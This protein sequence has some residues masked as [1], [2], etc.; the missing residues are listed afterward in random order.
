MNEWHAS[1]SQVQGYQRLMGIPLSK[2]I[3]L[4]I[5]PTILGEA[6]PTGWIHLSQQCEKMTSLYADT[7]YNWTITDKH[8]RI[9]SKGRTVCQ[10]TVALSRNEQVAATIVMTLMK[11]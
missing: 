5:L 3:P 10:L 6:F 7:F 11:G 2:E 8:L 4:S 9:T 1:L